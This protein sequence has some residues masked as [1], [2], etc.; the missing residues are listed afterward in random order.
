ML[1][2]IQFRNCYNLRYP[3]KT[4]YLECVEVENALCPYYDAEAACRKLKVLTK[5][6][7]IVIF[8]PFT[9]KRS[10]IMTWA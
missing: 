8:H 1:I 5:L 4:N 2:I 10:T 7:F 3:N 9:S 6:I